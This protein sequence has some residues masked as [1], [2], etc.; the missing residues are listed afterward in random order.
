MNI[1]KRIG[2]IT[3]IVVTPSNEGIVIIVDHSEILLQ[4]YLVSDL[5]MIDLVLE[6]TAF[7]TRARN[8]FFSIPV[9]FSLLLVC[10]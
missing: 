3:P 7:R 8:S 1:P 6:N 4:A 5:V 9:A 2:F 10:C